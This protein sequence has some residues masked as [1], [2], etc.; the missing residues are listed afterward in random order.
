MLLF[1]AIIPSNIGIMKKTT[2][3]LLRSR[4][5]IISDM[6]GIECAVSGKITEKIRTLSNGETATYYQLQRWEN[7]RN[8]TT[9]IP[10]ERLQALAEAAA[11]HAK[12]KAL[13]AELSVVDTKTVLDG[14]EPKKKRRR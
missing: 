9:H 12:L 1:F 13:V 11:G 10:K 2:S 3:A 14:S 4:A 6:N 5:E 7:G 8:V